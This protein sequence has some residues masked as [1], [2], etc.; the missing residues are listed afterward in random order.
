MQVPTT[1]LS[2]KDEITTDFLKLVD[3]HIDDLVNE[4]VGRRFHATDFAKLLFIHPRHLT[5]TVHLVTGTSQ[6]DIVEGKLI[7]EM[8]L[9]LNNTSLPIADIGVR[10]GFNDAANFT[11]FFKGME[12]RTPSSFRKSL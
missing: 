5:N 3:K 11:K 4:R 2:R 12:G 7:Y 6:C 10:F 1:V 8:K 9:L